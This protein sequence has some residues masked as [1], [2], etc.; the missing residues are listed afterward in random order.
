MIVEIEKNTLVN[1]F[2]V[3]NKK[4]DYVVLRNADEL[5]IKNHSNDIDILIKK[6]DYA[7]FVITMKTIFQQNGFSRVERTSFHGIECFTYYNIENH[8]PISIKIDLFFNVEGGGVFYFDFED[9]ITNKVKNQHGVY[10]LSEEFESFITAFKTIAAGGK[11]KDKY[12]TNFLK[13]DKSTYK[14]FLKRS[15]SKSLNNYLNFILDNKEN[16]K[17]VKRK[18][19]VLET[20]S[21]NFFKNPFKAISKLFYHFSLEF[22]RL[23]NSSRGLVLSDLNTDIDKKYIEILKTNSRNIFRSNPNRFILLKPNQGEKRINFINVLKL[24]RADKIVFYNELFF[25][26]S[27]FFKMIK[28]ILSIKPKNLDYNFENKKSLGEENYKNFLNQVIKSITKDIN[29][30]KQA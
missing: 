24:Q 23:F 6:K 25:K 13:F 21:T 5:P 29:N 15:P 9:V 16:P 12:L 8:F 10:V 28:S 7:D 18:N 4:Y 3:I 22:K 27:S 20:F 17:Y 1:F 30:P 19:I 11:L 14:D 2:D 26:Q